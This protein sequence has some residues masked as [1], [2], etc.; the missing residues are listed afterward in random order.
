MN[1]L[2]AEEYENYGIE[3]S[4]PASWVGGGVCR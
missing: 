1:Y 2:A 4:T 3:A